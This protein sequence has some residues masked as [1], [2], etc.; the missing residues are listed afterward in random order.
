MEFL[1]AVEEGRTE[2]VH[3]LLPRVN[4]PDD[5]V[6]EAA[7]RGYVEIVRLLLGDPRVDPAHD[8]NAAI[9]EAVGQNHWGVARLLLTDQRVRDDWTGGLLMEVV[10]AGRPD[11][12]RLLLAI[13]NFDV[14]TE[15]EDAFQVAVEEKHGDIVRIL[16]NDP[17]LELFEHDLD[18]YA[19]RASGET[20]KAI[21]ERRNK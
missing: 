2:D 4:P 19:Q 7:K 17:R 21:N 9:F 1:S 14:Y 3:R 15:G 10:R 18:W 5:I 16:L 6:E 8:M 12:V 11:I 13:E 20:L